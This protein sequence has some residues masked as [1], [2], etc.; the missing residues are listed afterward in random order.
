MAIL[1][2]RDAGRAGTAS[3]LPLRPAALPPSHALLTCAHPPMAAIIGARSV[4]TCEQKGLRTGD[5]PVV[6]V[7][8]YLAREGPR[9]ALED[10]GVVLDPGPRHQIP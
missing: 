4:Q 1:D 2:A 7:L 3:P 10:H 5:G 8:P 6:V 9:A